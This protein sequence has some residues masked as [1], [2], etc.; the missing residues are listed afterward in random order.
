MR[1]LGTIIQAKLIQAIHRTPFVISLSV[2]QIHLKFNF[3]C[4]H[5]TQVCA[6]GN[7]RSLDNP[8]CLSYRIERLSRGESAGS[9]FKS[10]MGD[11]FPIHR[12]DVY[13]AINRLR[14]LN[15]NKRALEVT[16]IP[17]FL[18]VFAVCS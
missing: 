14:K 11:G 9:A 17:L 4:T 2:I 8:K 12:G 15:M 6:E 5:T 7:P 16:S 1:I 3:L 13:H 18:C 10:W